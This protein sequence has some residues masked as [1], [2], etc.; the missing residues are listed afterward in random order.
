MPLADEG[1]FS[2]KNVQLKWTLAGGSE[3]IVADAT[4]IEI[5]LDLK[6]M[7]RTPGA[8]WVTQEVPGELSCVMK[9]KGWASGILSIMQLFPG[10]RLTAFTLLSRIS[11]TPSVLPASF[12]TYFPVAGMMLG[13]TNQKFSEKPSDWD[14]EIRTNVRGEFNPTYAP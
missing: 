5:P 13:K 8:S 1:Y 10:T 4:E 3:I 2:L 12:F 6:F 9:V 7:D 11:G 14:T